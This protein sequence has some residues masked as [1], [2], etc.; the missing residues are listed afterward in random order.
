[1]PG[2]FDGFI[3]EYSA[4]ITE[5]NFTIKDHSNNMFALIKSPPFVRGARFDGL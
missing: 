5:V 1:M 4:S 3:G 2:P